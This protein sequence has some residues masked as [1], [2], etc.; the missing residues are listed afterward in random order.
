MGDAQPARLL[1]ALDPA[2]GGPRIEQR[3]AAPRCAAL[4]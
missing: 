4:R 2:L 3:R 1:G